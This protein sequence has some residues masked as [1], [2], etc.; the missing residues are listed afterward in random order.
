[1]TCAPKLQDGALL[2]TSAITLGS[3]LFQGEF[4]AGALKNL[5][6]RGLSLVFFPP[7]M[8]QAK[9]LNRTWKGISPIW[10]IQHRAENYKVLPKLQKEVGTAAAVL[11]R[12]NLWRQPRFLF[13]RAQQQPRRESESNPQTPRTHQNYKGNLWGTCL[14]KGSASDKIKHFHHCKG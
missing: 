4:K 11:H 2:C 13:S 6:W 7:S 5:H 1:M 12:Q 8:G 10:N 14:R 9:Q 3:C